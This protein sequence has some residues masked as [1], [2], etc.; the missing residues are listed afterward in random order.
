MFAIIL[1]TKIF[2][3]GIFHCATSKKAV[4]FKLAENC[5]TKILT[6]SVLTN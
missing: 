2:I 3:Y 1:K 6:L 4:L 5:A